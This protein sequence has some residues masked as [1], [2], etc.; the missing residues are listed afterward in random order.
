M[1]SIRTFSR[2]AIPSRRSR[3]SVGAQPFAVASARRAPDVLRRAPRR[4]LSP[5]RRVYF[6][7]F[8][9]IDAAV[10]RFETLTPDSVVK[11]PAIVE[12][13][14]TSVVIDPGAMSHAKDPSGCLVIEVAA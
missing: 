12:S 13:G 11:G 1:R 10:L 5:A 3:P 9:W 14:F 2:S 8:G 4:S 6:R 7:P